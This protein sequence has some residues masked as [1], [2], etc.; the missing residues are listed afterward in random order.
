MRDT[1]NTMKY[2]RI[3]SVFAASLIVAVSGFH[4]VTAQQRGGSGLQISP[5]RNEIS[6]DPGEAKDFSVNV[7]NVTTG[8]VTVKAYLNDFEADNESGEP[9][10][11]VDE[12]V[13]QSPS[14]IKPFLKGLADFELKG[15]ATKE[16]KLS[17]D[18]PASTGAGGYYG[19][20]RFVALPKGADKPADRQVAL[21]ASVAS[22]VLAEVSGDITE[23]I[24]IKSVKAISGDRAGSFFFSKP[25]K[26]A[27][28]IQNEGNSFA[29]P[30]GRVQVNGMG[31]KEAYS[32]EL[33]NKD[34][35]G[36]ILPQSSRTFTDE[37]KNIKF[38]GRYTVLANVAYGSGGEV[39]TQKISFWYM[40]LWLLLVLVALIAVV[41][42]YGYLLYKRR[43]RSS[44]RRR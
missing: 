4:V 32:Y 30:F 12:N 20:V 5:T 37:I 15:G 16:V 43:G 26:V 42:G 3:L 25:D 1:K 33:N 7:K 9:N 18:I 28:D 44:S 13:Q 29:K 34:P 38:P 41:G 8:E 19:A 10:I 17:L 6:I 39:I 24:Q 22:L 21:N 2:R 23:Q 35:R 11:I 40:P 27:I 14:S 36:N 31:G